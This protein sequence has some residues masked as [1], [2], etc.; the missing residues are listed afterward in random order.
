MTTNDRYNESVRRMADAYSSDFAEF[1]AGDERIHELMMLLASEFV[2]THA[3]IV[4]EDSQ[5]DLAMELLMA[6]TVRPV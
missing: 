4:S 1:C 5:V 2:E 6:T 3:P